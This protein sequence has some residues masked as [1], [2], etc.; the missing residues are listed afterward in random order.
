MKWEDIFKKYDFNPVIKEKYEPVLK[1]NNQ[2]HRLMQFILLPLIGIL[3]ITMVILYFC[4]MNICI[5]FGIM[6]FLI[7]LYSILENILFNQ[8]M[9]I[10]QQIRKD[11]L[12]REE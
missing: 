12:N 10:Y 8:R 2:R 11:K 3:I 9:K 5:L 6:I 7:V 4:K 1:K